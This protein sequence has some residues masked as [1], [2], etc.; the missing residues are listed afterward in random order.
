MVMDKWIPRSRH[1]FKYSLATSIHFVEIQS[2]SKNTHP[3]IVA[4][5]TNIKI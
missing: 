3:L 4:L 5:D 2:D 1:T